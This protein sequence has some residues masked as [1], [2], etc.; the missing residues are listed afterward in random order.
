MTEILILGG[1]RWE[2]FVLFVRTWCA[3]F[4]VNEN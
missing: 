1:A 4:P 3:F 2:K